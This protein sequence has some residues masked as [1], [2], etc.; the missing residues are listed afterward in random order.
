[1]DRR[2]ELNMAFLLSIVLV[3]FSIASIVGLYMKEKSV[4]LNEHDQA[5]FSLA[6]SVDRNLI[7]KI[8]EMNSEMEYDLQKAE[9]LKIEE[10][11]L[12]TG[13][14]DE[15]IAYFRQSHLFKKVALEGIIVMEDSGKSDKTDGK[16]LFSI[17]Q[18]CKDE[19]SYMFLEEDDSDQFFVCYDEEGKYSIALQHVSH[20]SNLVYYILLDLNHF[21]D[22]I[23]PPELHKSHW[24]VFMDPETGLCLQ[25]HENQ[26]PWQVFSYDELMSRNDGYTMI[27]MNQINDMTNAQTYMYENYYNKKVHERLITIPSKKTANGI[28]A[29]GISKDSEDLYHELN[30]D[31]LC[32]FVISIVIGFFGILIY[33]FA[34]DNVNKSLEEKKELERKHEKARLLSELKQAQILN[35][36]RQMQPHFIY[37]ALGSIREIV[38]ENPEE[39]AELIYSFTQ[40]LRACL[41]SMTSNEMIPFEQEIKNIDA[42]INI[43]KMRLGEKL[44]IVY[45]IKENKF[46]I[47]PL[48]IQPL[49]ENAIR[50]G[51]CKKRG[52]TGTVVIR[53]FRNAESYVIE[54]EDDGIG[55]DVERTRTRIENHEQ[56]SIG[57][58]N[59][60]MR[61]KEQ[62][63]AEVEILSEAGKGTLVRVKIPEK[64]EIAGDLY[65][66]SNC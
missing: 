43:E 50:H 6:H 29:I 31:L 51:I 56:D 59:L 28:L 3:L 53:S 32:M 14:Y 63:D 1:M 30:V 49:V 64:K 66:S 19:H 20:Y 34:Y 35:A 27:A 45:D 10:S 17:C 37:N 41:K 7:Q 42:Y 36:T 16:I 55:F 21:Y 13:N 47:I 9:Y 62:L 11:M 8:D 54:V 61:F 65:A 44:H 25:N 40:F 52:K 23:I 18:S 24:V 5:L 38:L 15:V 22:T 60:I 48:G 26:K 58:Q 12:Q 4:I 33:K 57:I 39:G 2:K 46:L